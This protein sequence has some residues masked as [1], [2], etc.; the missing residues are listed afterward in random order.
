MKLSS[1]CIKPYSQRRIIKTFSHNYE[2]TPIANNLPTKFC[3]DCIHFVEP[4]ELECEGLDEYSRLRKGKCRLFNVVDPVSGKS[5]YVYA[6]T[7]RSGIGGCGMEGRFYVDKS[8]YI[9]SQI[10]DQRQ[11]SLYEK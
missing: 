6:A 10:S 11:Q 2:K 8:E 5:T 9:D 7:I 3:K 1:I 4:E